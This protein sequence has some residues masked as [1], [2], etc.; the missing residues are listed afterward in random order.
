MVKALI[1]LNLVAQPLYFLICHL[2][3]RIKFAMAAAATGR[4][5]SWNGDSSRRGDNPV[6]LSWLFDLHGPYKTLKYVT[7]M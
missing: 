3:R 2:S 7:E 5:K 1:Y 4:T 6:R